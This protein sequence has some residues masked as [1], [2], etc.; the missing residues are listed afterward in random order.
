M[1]AGR[2]TRTSRDG[3]HAVMSSSTARARGRALASASCSIATARLLGTATYTR[4]LVTLDRSP[5]MTRS[6][7]RT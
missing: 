2:I 4:P 7:A 5:E 1:A 6:T 3:V